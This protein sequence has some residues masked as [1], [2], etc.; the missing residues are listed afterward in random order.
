VICAP[1]S[2]PPALRPKLIHRKDFLQVQVTR[3]WYL[4][5]RSR[6]INYLDRARTANLDRQLHLDGRADHAADYFGRYIGREERTMDVCLSTNHHETYAQTSL[7]AGLT[8]QS[9]CWSLVHREQ[10]TLSGAA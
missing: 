8:A 7:E 3:K 1:D 4:P 9:I 10:Y 5:R 6:S 2:P